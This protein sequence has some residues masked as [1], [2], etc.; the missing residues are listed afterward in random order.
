[1]DKFGEDRDKLALAEIM[2]LRQLALSALASQTMH[3]L[4]GPAKAKKFTR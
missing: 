1:M 4:T 3:E 2:A